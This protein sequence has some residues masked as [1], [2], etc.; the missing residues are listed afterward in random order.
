MVG[1]TD[2]RNVYELVLDKRVINAL[3]TKP[4]SDNVGVLCR[5]SEKAAVMVTI[6]ERGIKLSVSVSVRITVGPVVSK[7]KV[8]LSVP[9]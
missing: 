6:A 3:V 5:L 8:I 9:E 1:D 7:V 4:V 2:Q